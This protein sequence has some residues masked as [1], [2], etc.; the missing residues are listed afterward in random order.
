MSQS[1][2]YRGFIYKDTVTQA[3]SSNARII[4]LMTGFA[5]QMIQHNVDL[6]KET[7]VEKSLGRMIQ[8]NCTFCKTSV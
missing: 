3:R 1:E 7:C 4:V 5:L 6:C 8:G 2:F